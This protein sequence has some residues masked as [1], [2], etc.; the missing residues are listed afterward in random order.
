MYV[1]GYRGHGNLGKYR[2]RC[3]IEVIF[4]QKGIAKASHLEKRSG[5]RSSEMKGNP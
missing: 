1:V 4:S 3:A 2:W 5:K